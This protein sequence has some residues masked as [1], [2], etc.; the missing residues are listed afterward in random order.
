MSGWVPGKNLDLQRILHSMGINPMQT[1]RV[2]I[3]MQPSGVTIYTQRVEDGLNELLLQL[4]DGEF[5]IKYA[6]KEVEAPKDGGAGS[7]VKPFRTGS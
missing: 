4:K 6:H 3:D 1:S 7:H 5:E 2:I